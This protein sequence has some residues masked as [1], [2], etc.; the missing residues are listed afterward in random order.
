MKTITIFGGGAWGRAL[1][2]ALSQNNRIYIVS[3][4]DLSD[5]TKKHQNIS[6]VTLK[7]A[8]TSDLSVCAIASSALFE[9]LSGANL[10]KNTKLLLASKGIDVNL[11]RFVG[12]ITK[13]FI[14]EANLCFLAGPSFAKEVLSALP[15]ALNIHTHEGEISQNIAKEFANAM[16][17]FIKTY[18]CD[19]ILG[20]QIAGAYKNVLAIACGICDGLTLGNN[21]RAALLSRGLNEMARFGQFYGAKMATF[22]GL[23]GAGDLF[24]S[25]SS[26][27]SRNYR[28][29]I[30]LAK[31]LPLEAILE[32][33]GEV[34]EGVKTT[35]AIYDLAKENSLYT[36][37]V[38][39]VWKILNAKSSPKNSLQTLMT[40]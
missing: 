9:W 5:F 32:D 12:D 35:F 2:Y 8:L 23:S 31:E 24:L 7:D 17:N 15:C 29:G 34:A 28:V 36:P 18:V 16:P 30:G 10:P 26:I 40:S 11:K 25:A 39:E 1:A 19:D 14:D 6:Q 37:I 33:L 21:A 4:K 22:W 20:A 27:L 3:R 13:D 38:S